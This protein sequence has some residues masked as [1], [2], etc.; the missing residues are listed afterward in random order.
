MEPRRGEKVNAMATKKQKCGHI[1]RVLNALMLIMMFCMSS[2]SNPL[3]VDLNDVEII[4][5]KYIYKDGKPYTGTV[6]SPSGYV[7]ATIE[8]EKGVPLETRVY[9]D[10]GQVAVIKDN[11]GL[12]HY[13]KTGENLESWE[14]KEGYPKLVKQ[15]DVL[16]S[17]I[18]RK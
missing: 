12:Y 4:N 7:K 16:E 9:H 17:F 3:R 11:S 18:E 15:I 6:Y 13:S 2:C 10:N 8:V 1:L 5:S 14:F